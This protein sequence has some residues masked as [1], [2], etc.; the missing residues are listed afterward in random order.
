LPSPYRRDHAAEWIGGGAPAAFG[1]GGAA[2]AVVDPAT[3]GLLGGV[4]IDRVLSERQ[5]AEV[6]YWVGP[7]ARGRG[8]A[9]DAVRTVA[10]WAFSR[11]LD[12][13]ELLTDWSNLP[14]QRVAQAAGFRREGVRRG[15]VPTAGVSA[16]TDGDG[17]AGRRDCLVFARL[18][19]DLPGP[20]ARA[21]PDLPGGDLTDGVVT[22][23]PLAPDDTDVVHALHSVPD[24]AAVA[25]P[26]RPPQRW[27]SAQR[28]ARAGARWLAGERVELLVTDAVTGTA[29]GEVQLVWQVPGEATIGYSLLPAFRG[30]GLATLAVRL[31]A[32]WT[33]A[34]TGTGRL[35]AI[36]LPTNAASHRVLERAGFRYEGEVRA[37]LRTA[38]GRPVDGVRHSLV[39]ADLLREVVRR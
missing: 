17:A 22:L 16:P 29:A 14:S 39:A 2:F 4:G 32:L 9:T 18:A 7:W 24:V 27:E 28:C 37:G 34:E 12:R 38:D 26:A 11:G 3:D 19:G 13:L 20:L 10:G 15:A 8:V 6:G 30:R 35:V 31:L 25:V 1:A 21:L 23:T 5:Q 33:F 36:S